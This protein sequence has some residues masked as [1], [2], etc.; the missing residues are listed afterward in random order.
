[1]E[2]RQTINN[3]VAFKNQQS[4]PEKHE[5]DRAKQ[6]RGLQGHYW[7]PY[8]PEYSILVYGQGHLLHVNSFFQRFVHK[9]VNTSDLLVFTLKLVFLLRTPHEWQMAPPSRMLPIGLINS[10]TPIT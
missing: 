1:M 2:I 9:Y 6:P 10:L 8:R 5:H 3:R 4:T 7:T